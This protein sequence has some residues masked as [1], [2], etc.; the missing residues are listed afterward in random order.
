[1]PGPRGKGKSKSKHG[2]SSTQPVGPDPFV[3]D[4]QHVE[5]WNS[6]VRMFCDY[7]KLPGPFLFHKSQ[8]IS[9]HAALIDLTTRTGL[10]RVHRDF[11]NIY[12]R[13]DSLYEKNAKNEKIV[14]GVIG[15]CAKLCADSILRDKL[16]KAGVYIRFF[17]Y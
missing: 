17:I 3:G 5:G 4:I 1:M 2:P 6:I 16:F 10:K 14:G 11:D 15:V 13:L 8:K 12:R 9:I 7:L